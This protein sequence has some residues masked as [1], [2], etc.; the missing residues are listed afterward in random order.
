MLNLLLAIAL[1]SIA[2]YRSITGI[3]LYPGMC[4]S[5]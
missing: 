5:R 2:K 3:K 4:L 1:T